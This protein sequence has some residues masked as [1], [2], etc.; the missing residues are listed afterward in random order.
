MYESGFQISFEKRFIRY[1]KSLS[2]TLTVDLKNYGLMDPINFLEN[3]L[4][5]I[6]KNVM[7][8]VPFFVATNAVSDF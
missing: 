5:D 8:T 2:S 4:L 1:S 6:L 3:V 7:L